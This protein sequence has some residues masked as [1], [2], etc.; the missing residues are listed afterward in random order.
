[1]R[2]AATRRIVP[3][4][5]TGSPS[6]LRTPLVHMYSSFHEGFLAQS[7][8][9]PGNGRLPRR[10]A[11]RPVVSREKIRPASAIKKMSYPEDP[12]SPTRKGR[13]WGTTAWTESARMKARPSWRRRPRDSSRE[14]GKNRRPSSVAFP[15][16]HGGKLYLI[17][18]FEFSFQAALRS[19]VTHISVP[20]P[21]ERL[22]AD[23]TVTP[24]FYGLRRAWDS[25]RPAPR[26]FLENLVA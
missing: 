23:A 9:A 7:S 5:K 16:Q 14:S 22:R 3:A 19:P 1:M 6:S 13:N 15:R 20:G 26:R 24:M 2:T 8:G 17:I 25:D 12:R 21:P 4:H 10:P 18:G 11:L